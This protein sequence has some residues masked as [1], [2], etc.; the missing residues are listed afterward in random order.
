M[1]LNEEQV[2][3]SEFILPVKKKKLCGNCETGNT[4]LIGL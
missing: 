1:E 4:L 3:I 2:L